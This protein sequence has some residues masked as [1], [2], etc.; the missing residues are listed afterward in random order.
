[1]KNV[2]PEIK[3]N[4]NRAFFLLVFSSSISHF[5][6]K[7]NNFCYLAV[8]FYLLFNKKILFLYFI[9]MCVL[10]ESLCV[11]VS[12]NAFIIY[13]VRS[14]HFIFAGCRFSIRLVVHSL[15]KSHDIGAGNIIQFVFVDN[16]IKLNYVWANVSYTRFMYFLFFFLL[17]YCIR[18]TQFFLSYLRIWVLFV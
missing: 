3:I 5:C 9:F 16:W 2:L 14:F 10:C 6:A 12:V 8:T 13:F 18:R 17:F 15:F 1:M 7:N 4:K 11:N